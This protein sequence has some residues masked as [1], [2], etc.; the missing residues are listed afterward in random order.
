LVIGG[1]NFI[2]YTNK[3]FD[4]M[5]FRWL[6]IVFTVSVIVASIAIG[7]S[8]FP[9]MLT[10]LGLFY[11]LS[12]VFD[13]RFSFM[14]FFQPILLI[15]IHWLSGMDWCLALYWVQTAAHFRDFRNPVSALL[16]TLLNLCAY[17]TVSSVLNPYT[18]LNLY[19]LA[20]QSVSFFM[21]TLFFYKFFLMI[22]I[23]TRLL[24]KE[25]E[26]LT[27]YDS[28]TGL[29]K[30]E[31]FHKRLENLVYE[32][33]QIALILL[34]CHDLKTLNSINGFHEVNKLLQQVAQLLNNMFPEALLIARYGGDEFALVLKAD[35]G[36]DIVK[37]IE[38][39]LA[40]EFPK[41]TGIRINYGV[42][43]F[44]FDAS[45]KDDL[46]LMAEKWLFTKKREAWLK[47][48]EQIA[49]S[50][51]LRIVGELASGM[52]HEIRNPLTTVKGFLQIA[53]ANGYKV[54]QWYELI[55]NEIDRMSILTGEFLQFSKPHPK[56][57][58]IHALQDCV[59]RV[60]SLM[61]SETA[62]LGHTLYAEMPDKPV[63]IWMNHNKIIQL[64][65]NMVKNAFEAMPVQGSVVIKLTH[66]K[67]QAVIEIRDT[68]IGMTPAELEQIFTPFYTT[69][70]SGTGLGLA[71]CH[72]II[73]DHQGRLEV[74]S[75]K[76]KG[77]TFIITLPA[78]DLPESKERINPIF[79]AR[80]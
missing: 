17:V 60:I 18:L 78:S 10:I 24:N 1:W 49:R 27:T 62:R 13:H 32:E 30:F 73:Q 74:E 33:Q 67:K 11:M 2:R 63:Y 5:N 26:R 76:N 54:E 25:K 39:K 77:T 19:N 66:D 43:M 28:L 64:L 75:E 61:E 56:E 71:I 36:Q 52:A 59:N 14:R 31:E 12:H 22:Q 70:E 69:K 9:F 35:N 47:Q 44:P 4:I 41:L 57:F 20:F 45:T 29:M 38:Q 40:S 80:K 23:K 58:Q 7:K 68:G 3:G 16:V 6:I 48:E 53:K 15:G 50:E 42:A 72:K 34:D 37:D 55:M 65:L 46:I 21:L 8:N 79:P 51:Q